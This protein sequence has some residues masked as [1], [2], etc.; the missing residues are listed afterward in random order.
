MDLH[1]VKDKILLKN[2]IVVKLKQL[3]ME[4]G[5]LPIS[6]QEENEQKELAF[7]K[8]EMSYYENFLLA[9]KND[10]TVFLEN[11]L[12]DSSLKESF[13]T[14][15]QHVSSTPAKEI[16]LEYVDLTKSLM[17]KYDAYSDENFEA[18]KKAFY[19]GNENLIPKDRTKNVNELEEEPSSVLSQKNLTI[20]EK[21]CLNSIYS[22]LHQANPNT[23]SVLEFNNFSAQFKD[24]L[25]LLG[26]YKF[27]QFFDK[28][29][30]KITDMQISQNLSTSLKSLYITNFTLIDSQNIT[31]QQS[32]HAPASTSV[33]TAPY[34]QT[35][36]YTFLEAEKCTRN[37]RCFCDY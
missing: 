27:Q 8:D 34:Y 15:N 28:E 36:C 33:L 25:K 30:K 10:D 6:P 12:L 11:L 32:I 2:C 35:L 4:I 29:N 7:L 31:S 3:K 17:E 19:K 24:K 16:A 18:L 14:F 22:L 26:I 9:L 1:S 5:R 23:M 37:K 21:D 20:E 13:K